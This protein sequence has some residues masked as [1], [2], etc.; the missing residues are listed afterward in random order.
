MCARG[1]HQRRERAGA[2]RAPFLAVNVLKLPHLPASQPLAIAS[3]VAVVLHGCVVGPDYVAPQVLMPDS[4]HR[5]A[6]AGLE[7]G[8]ASLHNW[9]ELLEDPLLEQLIEQAVR[10]NLDLHTAFARVDEARA[11]RGVAGGARYP[12]IDGFGAVDRRRVS[13]GT[14]SDPFP[15]PTNRTDTIGTL[16]VGATWEI[17]LWGRISREIESADAGLQASVENYRDVL[18]VLLAEVASA[19]VEVRTLQARINSAESN[20]AAQR[21]TVSLTQDRQRAGIAPELHVR[22]AE[23]TLATTESQIPALEQA[24]ARAVHRLGVLLGEPPFAL[25]EKLQAVE[26]V[27]QSPATLAVSLPHELLRQ[28]PDIRR[29]ERELAAQHARIGIATADLYP[30]FSLSGF[31]SF[32]G[33]SDL[34]TYKNTAWQFGPSFIWNLFD[35]GRVRNRILAED[36][37][38]QQALLQYRQRILLAMEEVENAIVGYTEERKRRD[39]LARSVTAARQA[40]TLVK[41]L[42]TSGL[43]DFQNVRDSERSLFIQQDLLAESEGLVIL[44]LIALYRALGGGWQP[45]PTQLAG[46]LEDQE[47]TKARL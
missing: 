31:F 39:T 23:L 26:P 21:D 45:D 28:R 13:E 4:W 20:A 41:A 38:T 37:R 47:N 46:E 29:A 17:D 5:A 7:A 30:R 22:Q 10:G 42:Y 34:L 9:W 43:T 33:T 40:V 2:T 19:Y 1:E 24:R 8:N 32:Q 25:Y 14:V 11:I 36:A 16:G 15:P 12:Q 44:Q 35:G 27:P 6:T 3:M 18:V